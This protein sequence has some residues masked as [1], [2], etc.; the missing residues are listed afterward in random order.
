MSEATKS[1]NVQV[2]PSLGSPSTLGEYLPALLPLVGAA[3][4]V[5]VRKRLGPAGFPEDGALI[6]VGL[7]CY[8][9]AAAMHATNVW[10][11]SR[12][13]EKIGLWTAS[14][15]FFFNLS[16]WLVRWITAGERESWVR[17]TNQITG[18]YHPWWFFSY[19]PFANLYDLS[20]AFAFGAAFATLLIE[21]RP[22]ARFVGALSLPLISL[23]LILA[24]FIGNEFIN[25]PP[26]LDSYW[27]PIHVGVA[28]MSYGV[29]LVSF[30]IAVMYL[31]K[32]GV[33]IESMAVYLTAFV[34][35]GIAYFSNAYSV[36]SM[37]YSLNPAILQGQTV[38]PLKTVRVPIP[39]VGLLLSISL[40]LLLTVTVCFLL[41]LFKKNEGARRIGHLALR[42]SLVTQGLGIIWLFY[43]IKHLR[44]LGQLIDAS[45]LRA[46]GEWLAGSEASQLGVPQLV[47]GASNWLQQNGSTLTLDQRANPVEIASLIAAFVFTLFMVLFSVGR[48]RIRMSLPSLEKLD[49]LTYKTVGVAFAGLAILLV[50]GAVWANESW[51]KY[52]SWDSKEVGALVAWL[53]YAGYLHTRIA[54]GWS[55]RRSAYFAVVGFLLVIFTYL[56]VSYLLPGLHSYA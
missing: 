44:N 1:I 31:I 54:H 17:M 24:V 39:G 15:G 37:S 46:L 6:A 55:G 22:N 13:L 9:T 30:A 29:A 38:I 26:V 35:A 14:L 21:R 20:L 34:V 16:S 32:D 53:A 23:V 4:M 40:L 33:K 56:G 42:A 41:Y 25:L 51:G 50:T 12:I 18:E 5:V 48:E 28:S 45:Q 36:L 10:A 19:I 47:Q 2:A 49:S 43:E 27:R 52:W 11:P 3:I 7:F 8:I